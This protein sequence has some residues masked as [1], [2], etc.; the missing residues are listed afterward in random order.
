MAHKLVEAQ[1]AWT[2]TWCEHGNNMAVVHRKAEWPWCA[3]G[4]MVECHYIDDLQMHVL[5]HVAWHDMCGGMWYAH[6]Q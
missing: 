2:L 3:Q 1:H 4:H 6:A 5:R